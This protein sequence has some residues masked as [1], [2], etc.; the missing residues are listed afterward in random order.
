MFF[1]DFGKITGIVE[2]DR[3]G[4]HLDVF[5]GS[6]NQIQRM[7]HSDFIEIIGKSHIEF[8]PKQM[9]QIIS[10]DVDLIRHGFQ[11]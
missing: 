11:T 1:E 6:V 4:N 5:A 2:A 9:A 8:F 3:F 7:F 10:A